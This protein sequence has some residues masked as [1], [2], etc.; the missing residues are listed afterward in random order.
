[1]FRKNN[2][3]ALLLALML[4][5]TL[6]ACGGGGSGGDDEGGS[7]TTVDDNT[8]DDSN[9]GDDNNTPP[10]D[11]DTTNPD[12]GDNTP[13]EPDQPPPADDVVTPQPV[14]QPPEASI[15]GS[16]SSTSGETVT[17]DGSASSDPDDDSLSYLWTQTGGEA[18]NLTNNSNPT[19]TFIA[20]EVTQSSS[21]SL[22]LTVNDGEYSATADITIQLSPAADNTAPAVTSRSPLA[23]AVG[24]STTTQVSVSFD[25][26]LDATLVD[27]QS[28]LVTQAGSSV[29]ASVSYNSN[30]DSLILSFDNP[31]LANTLYRVTL[32]TNLQDPSGNQVP[33]ESWEFTTGSSYN[34]G[35]TSQAT[36]DACMDENDKL[37]L[38]LVN[39]AR[40][41][42]RNCGGTN[43][44]AVEAIAWHCQL[45][46]AAQ[47]HSTSMADNDYFSHT[48]LDDSSPGDR[49]TAAGYIWRAYA[50]NIAAGYNDEEAVMTAWLESPGHCA[51]IM[52]TSV[53]E[54]GAGVAENP[55]ARYR[56]YWTQD[57]ADQ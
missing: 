6:I 39:N 27:N 38:T 47:N 24:V 42:S 19:L 37:M 14:N 18:I 46:T 8:Q 35:S 7:Q 5:L 31:L 11:T 57:F 9:G 3:K 15:S 16:Q 4:S 32:G 36:I 48:G 45:E 40:A 55:S 12:E 10:D 50:E 13:V 26:P 30:S 41:V 22:R 33:V 34:L 49:I 51:N 25:E 53:T 52:N 54:M 17:L 56:I 44:S 23:D 29:T 2:T 28:L 43:Y 1:M 21:L 20:P